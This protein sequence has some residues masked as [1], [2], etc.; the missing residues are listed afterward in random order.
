MGE[1]GTPSRPSMTFALN[2]WFQVANVVKFRNSSGTTRI[3]AAINVRRLRWIQ[4]SVACPNPAHRTFTTMLTARWTVPRWTRPSWTTSSP[5]S[6]STLSFVIPWM[7][8]D[9]W[10]FPR[11]MLRRTSLLMRNGKDKPRRLLSFPSSS[12]QLLA[13]TSWNS[14]E[15]SNVVENFVSVVNLPPVPSYLPLSLHPAFVTGGSWAPLLPCQ[16]QV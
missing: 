6:P 15:R 4:S 10:H 3:P 9:A 5:T 14:S 8:C 1:L 13:K 11:K 7:R 2:C 16:G 12:L